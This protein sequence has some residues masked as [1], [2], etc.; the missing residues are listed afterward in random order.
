MS[1]MMTMQMGKPLKRYFMDWSEAFFSP[2]HE[3][4]YP[5]G[6]DIFSI[7][8]LSPCELPLC[9]HLDKANTVAAEFA[10]RYYVPQQ[11]LP[12]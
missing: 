4:V 8:L 2:S 9:P 11:A 7:S 10:V 12:I 5:S 1:N 6:R 3:K